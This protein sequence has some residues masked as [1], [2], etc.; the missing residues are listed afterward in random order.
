MKNIETLVKQYTDL[1]NN[2]REESKIK[3]TTLSNDER[4]DEANLEKIKLN[5]YDVFNTLVGATHKQ[6]SN[7]NYIDDETKYKAFCD[8]YLQTFDKI[9]QSWRIKL[10]KAKDHN[11][12]I[13]IVIE[14]AKLSVAEELK[15][16]F[17][18]LV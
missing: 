13:D 14:E 1:L 9:P 17:T 5:I 15:N 8:A 18:N 11:N 12:T 6:I 2:K 3:C 7:K 16:I 10:E 4:N